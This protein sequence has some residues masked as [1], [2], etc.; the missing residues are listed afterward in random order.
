MRSE[1]GYYYTCRLI[2]DFND[3]AATLNLLKTIWLCYNMHNPCIDPSLS[4]FGT[5]V[6]LQKKFT[7][8]KSP[9]HINI[10]TYFQ[11]MFIHVGS[12]RSLLS[13][14][15]KKSDHIVCLSEQ[16][17]HL[18]NWPK[19]RLDRNWYL[20]CLLSATLRV[21]KGLGNYHFD[22]LMTIYEGM[23]FV[24]CIFWN[25]PWHFS[26]HR[27]I[28]YIIERFGYYFLVF[29][30]INYHSIFYRTHQSISWRP[31]DFE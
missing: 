12:Y 2:S 27:A 31:T 28:N 21:V 1:L 5:T 30:S 29:H 14:D 19:S 13:Y 18:W 9:P 7:L 10:S 8:F 25:M 15:T 23:C 4:I 6:H 17:P 3:N 24:G 16:E 22:G 20:F 11:E 26:L